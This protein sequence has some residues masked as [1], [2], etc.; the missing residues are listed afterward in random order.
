MRKVFFLGVQDFSGPALHPFNDA[1]LHPFNDAGLHP[2]N[3]AGLHPFNDAGLHPFNRAVAAD[4][5]LSSQTLA[6][7]LRTTRADLFRADDPPPKMRALSGAK[8]E[9][10]KLRRWEPAPR[11]EACLFELL[12]SLRFEHG[13]LWHAPRLD[14]QGASARAIKLISITAPD[15]SGLE[16]QAKLVLKRTPERGDRLAEI[17]V[18]VDDLWS[19]WTAITNLDPQTVART[20][21]VVEFA[22]RF[23]TSVVMR[24]KHDLACPRP[25]DVSASVQPVIRTPGHGSLPSGHATVAFM[26]RRVLTALLD[27]KAGDPIDQQLERLAHRVADNRVVA[28]LHY[29]MDSVAGRLLGETLADAFVSACT[30]KALIVAGAAFNGKALNAKPA[31]YFSGSPLEVI[32]TIEASTNTPGSKPAEAWQGD[33]VLA[34]C[35]WRAAVNELAALGFRP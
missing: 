16:E 4:A 24:L 27:V 35:M 12:S 31:D 19:F 25:A 5:A 20:A 34:K 11:M 10:D 18:Q 22:R 14:K 6:Q 13:S 26:V 29:P 33:D 1:G 9:D 23:A 21:E 7:A 8:R 15:D 30:G 28:G 17:L 2:F 32:T 3:D